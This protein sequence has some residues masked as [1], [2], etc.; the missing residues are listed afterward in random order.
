MFRY[1][2][3]EELTDKQKLKIFERT[4]LILVVTCLKELA[5][6]LLENPEKLKIKRVP[7]KNGKGY[8]KIVEVPIPPLEMEFYTEDELKHE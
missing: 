3:N 6:Y 8:Q 1:I 4:Q 5:E 7:F 2:T